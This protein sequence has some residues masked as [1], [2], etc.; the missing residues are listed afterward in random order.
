AS[1]PGVKHVFILRVEGGKGAFSY[2]PALAPGETIRGVIPS[3]AQAS[4]V[5]HFS[6]A[7]ADRLAERLVESGLYAKEA[8]AMVNTWR[9]SYF[10]TE[11]VRALFVLPQEWT[12]Q[13]IPLTINPTPKAV[14]RVMVGRMEL[15]TPERERLA[16]AAVRDLASQDT[17]K[18]LAAFQTLNAQGRYV[19]P[20]VRRVVTTTRDENVRD[21][22]RRLLLADFVTDLRS[23]VRSPVATQPIPPAMVF[24]EEPVYIRARLAELLREVGQSKEAKVEGAAA[25]AQLKTRTPVPPNNC[26]ARHDLKAMALALEGTGDDRGAAE[27][28]GRLVDLGGLAVRTQ[29]CRKCHQ[30]QGAEIAGKLRD[31]WAGDAYVRA[32]QRCGGPEQAIKASEALLK[33]PARRDGAR[34]RLAFLYR[35]S[36]RSAESEVLWSALGA[37]PRPVTM[38]DQKTIPTRAR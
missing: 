19:E 7:L 24:N 4:P 30:Q 11:G 37:A 9:S 35:A 5:E 31:W 26:E 28:Y 6:S 15:L 21:L 32:V 18:R 12:D 20:I 8:R 23:A 14:T 16:E 33:E 25:L 22:C 27:Q 1:G 36:E 34:L 13:S 29:E 10:G 17:A 2:R 3:L 38:E